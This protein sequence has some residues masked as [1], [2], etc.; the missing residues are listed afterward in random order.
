LTLLKDLERIA[1]KANSA[2]GA[3]AIL[4]EIV[5]SVARYSLWSMCWVGLLDSAEDTVTL[6]YE[7]GFGGPPPWVADPWPVNDSPSMAAIRRGDPLILPDVLAADEF[8]RVQRDGRQRGFRGVLVVPMRVES[9]CGVLWLC[10][11][12]PHDFTEAEIAFAT[13]VAALTAI[14]LT[15]ARY[16]TRERALK[17]A[18]RAQLG[19]L[20]RLHDLAVRQNTELQ[21][22]ADIHDRLLKEMLRD[23]GID[24]LTEAI[25][26]LVEAPVII[27]NQ[28]EQIVAHARIPVD[29]AEDIAAD[30]RQ[31]GRRDRE[32]LETLRATPVVLGG[33]QCVVAPMVIGGTLLGYLCSAPGEV[34][35]DTIT[36][37]EQACLLVGLE[38]FKERD[39]I[40]TEL[41][42]N[43]DVIE[44]LLAGDESYG[45]R[46]L[47]SVGI[48]ASGTNRVL[49]V[50]GDAGALAAMSDHSRAAIAW[51]IRQRLSP[52]FPGTT[53]LLA[54]DSE[55]LV[56]IPWDGRRTDSDVTRATGIIRTALGEVLETDRAA[57]G[58]P[59]V[60]VGI[61]SAG[62]GYEGIRASH[63][64][65]TKAL[66][67]A[68]A[69]G[70]ADEDMSLARAGIYRLLIDLPD[71][72]R[73]GY[74]RQILRPLLD[75]DIAHN[76]DLVST[77]ETYLDCFGSAQRTAERLYLHVT[78]VRYRLTRIQQISRLSLDDPHDRLALQV[79]LYLSR[80]ERADKHGS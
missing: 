5:T 77:L 62:T 14:A 47:S 8:P 71:E 23:E 75:Y 37:L 33:R 60:N 80:S 65:A 4:S 26:E 9:E 39:K 59:G 48:N 61:G 43:R 25:G 64:E 67:I 70:L 46:R 38:L 6:E 30:L 58:R 74:A 11:R 45:Q 52:R 79:A 12:E 76:S 35:A 57:C 69:L 66:R 16:V 17:E 54:T 32:G 15:T 44:S 49:R 7:S 18:E 72:L 2:C 63:D 50:H 10:T 36:T 42:M 41:R 73:S 20:K 24:P 27:L 40:E 13:V 29:Q 68:S 78:T 3:D 53:A 55:Y 28:F 21:R 34:T 56:V 1:W 19:E 22:I 51:V 31:R